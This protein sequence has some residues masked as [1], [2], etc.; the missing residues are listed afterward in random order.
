MMVPV[1]IGATEM[2][3]TELKKNFEVILV[4]RAVESLHKTA[5]LRT[6]HIIWKVLR[7]ET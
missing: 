3:R 5:V 4:K 1:I 7:T 6:S 2:A